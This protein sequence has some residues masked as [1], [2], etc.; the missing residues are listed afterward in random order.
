MEEGARLHKLHQ[1]YLI[2]KYK[3]SDTLYRKEVSIK[4]EVDY[5]NITYIINGRAD[6]VIY[7]DKKIIVEEIKSVY[8][9]TDEL[10]FFYNK[11]YV[12][13]LLMYC[14]F[15]T[16]DVEYEIIE[17]TIT[18]ISRSDEC[19]KS[20][21]KQYTKDELLEYFI[22]MI[23]SYYKFSKVDIDNKEEMEVSGKLV[24]FPYESYRESQRKF[25]GAVYNSIDN[26]TKL[27][28]QAPTGVGKTLSTLF[29]SIKAIA[30]KKGKKIFYITAKT[31]TKNVCFET[32]EMLFE[33][34]Y[35][36]IVLNISSKE[37]IC[38]N[39]E[40]NCNADFCQYAKGYYD[41]INEAIIDI[42]SSE[43]I[44]SEKVVRK[45]AKKHNVCP[46]FF[47]LEIIDFVHIVVCDY[48]YVYNPSVCFTKYF[49]KEKNDFIVLVDEAHNLEDRSRDFFSATINKK[50]FEYLQKNIN[51]NAI[52]RNC[53]EIINIFKNYMA[54]NRSYADSSINKSLGNLLND[55]RFLLDEYFSENE[56]SEEI[57]EDVLGAYFSV[58]YYLKTALYYDEKYKTV[59]ET[60]KYE[61]TITLF[62]VDTSTR[63]FKVNTLCRS[64]VFFSATLTPI[65]YFSDI[66]GGGKDDYFIS[67]ETSFDTNNQ[68]TLID[69]TVSTYYKDREYSYKKIAEKID[70]FVNSK[71]GNYF[72]FFPSYKFLENTVE[73][74]KKIN[75]N[76]EIFTQTKDLSQKEREEF[77]L[78]FKN[79]RGNKVAFLVCGGVFSEGVN[80]VGE[81]LIG[82][83]VVG[84][85]ISMLN[86]KS[87][88][89]KDYYDNKN[90][91]G[92]EFA[93][94]YQGF[95]KILQSAGRVIRSNEDRGTILFIDTRLTKKQYVDLFPKHYKNFETIKDNEKLTKK[96]KEFW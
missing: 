5:K 28:A 20:F 95:N 30:N 72:V 26:K 89:I 79:S 35:K 91:M 11:A 2:Q 9:I 22:D 3:D 17:A 64:V 25:M 41:R 16:V 88:V 86:F 51:N 54:D 70:V 33:E 76:Y 52:N 67:L 83:V 21:T 6:S 15:L 34:G 40:I 61:S 69:D 46:Y 4:R 19:K 32:Q 1:E 47:Q 39:T 74:F 42:I 37:N 24:E 18:Y 45:Y 73:S 49:D 58:D 93:Y 77:L 56:L 71:S 92:Y 85:G 31:I 65:S 94:M 78:K 27:F 55:L 7:T 13:Q 82:A 84:V 50:E 63:F 68:L 43:K 14:Y 36:G 23:E 57:K 48:N 87:D 75:D 96:L 90:N 62:C 81:S 60:N 8:K 59:Y 12:A 66:F 29:P 38:N 53:K 44:L 10:S 80:L